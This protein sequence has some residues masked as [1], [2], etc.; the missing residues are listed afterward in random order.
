MQNKLCRLV[1]IYII[2]AGIHAIIA[3]AL[4]FEWIETTIS[5]PGTG[6]IAE[7]TTEIFGS[8]FHV[9]TAIALLV[10]IEA[11]SEV[12]ALPWKCYY[13]SGLPRLSG[14]SE[15]LTC[16]NPGGGSP[17]FRSGA[18]DAWSTCCRNHSDPLSKPRSQKEKENPG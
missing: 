11:L 4:L 5:A 15:S 3:A 14:I 8:L 16:N 2:S 17:H 13:S 10:S 6:F 18:L 7:S 12:T 9:A 1:Y